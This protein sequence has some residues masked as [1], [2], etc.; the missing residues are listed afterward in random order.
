MEAVRRAFLRLGVYA[1][2]SAMPLGA[3]EVSG[4]YTDGTTKDLGALAGNPAWKSWRI[5]GWL[6]LYVAANANHVDAA[7]ADAHR[8]LSAVRA[9]RLT[10]EGRT[11]DV[12]SGELRL[13]LAEVEL[14]KVPAADRPAG[15][16]GFKVD[17]AA[18]DTQDVLYDTIRAA[19]PGSVGPLDR[20][21]QHAS[22]SYLAPVGS[23]LRL[24]LGKFAT[25]LGVESIE[26]IKNRNFSHTYG[27]TYAIPFQ[28]SGLRANYV[29]SP[30][31]YG[32]L[33]VLRGWNVTTDNNGRPSYGLTL[34]WTPSSR[35]SVTA[36]YLGGPE[37][38]GDDRDRR[39]L[40]DLAVVCALTPT[41]Q[42]ALGADVG[43]DR[44]AV[45]PGRD[46]TWSGAVFYLRKSLAERY[47]PTLRL[48]VYDDPDGFTTGVAQRVAA[49]T[50]TGDTRL[51]SR[52]GFARLLLRPELRYDRSSA[53]FFSRDGQFRARRDQATAELG[54]V[55]Y[56]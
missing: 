23:G 12:R 24:D 55:G 40:G 15:R 52:K 43:R 7:T 34:G 35:W 26:S 38:N 42:A 2:L 6:E 22:I 49:L 16:F 21:I 11:F 28:D 10:I 56:F 50:L 9:R 47:F 27:Y 48:E 4:V 14:E 30:K 45:S 17:L 37:R 3:Q 5:R 44:N 33:Y 46:A 31:L 13:S 41:L 20:P 25:H 29:F 54:L 53:P 8:S 19:S 39:D 1:V 36:N 18:G 32:E 51:G